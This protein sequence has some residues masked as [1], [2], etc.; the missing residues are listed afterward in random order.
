MNNDNERREIPKGR[1]ESAVNAPG[2]GMKDKAPG[3]PGVSPGNASRPIPSRT[4]P[5]TAPSSRSA[6]PHPGEAA[7]PRNASSPPS[8]AAPSPQSAPGQDVPGQSVPKQGVPGQGAPGQSQDAA[9]APQQRSQ[10]RP[11]RRQSSGVR[12]IPRRTVSEADRIDNVTGTV[13]P[14]AQAAEATSTRVIPAQ[15]HQS[16]ESSPPAKKKSRSDPKMMDRLREE[17]NNAVISLVKAAIYLVVV[18][19]VSIIISMMVILVGNDMYAF[20]KEEN[21]VEVV[22]PVGATVGDLTDILADAG[23]IKYPKVFKMYADHKTKDNKNFATLEFVPSDYEMP[24]DKSAVFIAGTYKLN[25]GMDYED[26]LWSFLPPDKT[27]TSWITIPEGFTTDE[28]IDLL[29]ENGIGK[30]EN[31][32]EVI[33]TYDFSSFWFVKELED[34]GRWSV[35]EYKQNGK[36]SSGRI[37]RLDGYLF[38]DTYEF[39]NA[40]N[41]ETVIKKMLYRFSQIFSKEYRELTES[42]GFTVDELITLSSMV[43]KEANKPNDFFNVSEVFRNRLNAPDQFPYLQS[44]ATVLYQIHHDTGERPKRVSHDDTLREIPYNTYTNE[45]LPPG[46]ISNPSATAILAALNP[47]SNGYYYFVSGPTETHFS[48]SLWDHNYWLGITSEEWANYSED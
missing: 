8:E 24:E 15:G 26:L 39:Y 34:S 19:V 25:T 9:P 20:V 18:L 2:S 12:P 43:E 5:T 40:S 4:I 10:V 22:V 41:E 35:E 13:S 21:D 7:T 28:I 1:P 33:N 31:Y 6:S 45:G 48:T 27:G 3:S 47:S 44:D 36:V 14:P 23:L 11:V 29:V 30:R 16:R 46:P 17:G 42:Q 38:P 37:Y 32:V